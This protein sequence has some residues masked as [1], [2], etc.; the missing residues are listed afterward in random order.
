MDPE[1]FDFDHWHKLA[2]NDPQAF[3]A[4]RERAIEACIAS[5]P[6]PE[7]RQEMRQLQDQIDG[8]RLMAGGPERALQGIATMLGD[9]LNAL[10]ANLTSLGEETLRLSGLLGKQAR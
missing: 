7:G 9:H 3:F 1:N 10:T 4:Q 5:N 2:V 8:L 6:R